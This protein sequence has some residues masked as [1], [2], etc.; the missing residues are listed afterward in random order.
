MLVLRDFHPAPSSA[1]CAPAAIKALSTGQ[2]HAPGLCLRLAVREVEAWALAD[3]EGAAR[4]FA[5]PKNR[6]PREPDGLTDPKAALVALCHRSARREI[7]DG[8]VPRVGSGRAVGPAYVALLTAFAREWDAERASEHSPSLARG[9]SGMRS[10]VVDG[11]W[12]S[13]R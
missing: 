11:R 3:L 2:V 6:I 12:S 1:T 10:C 4:F 7:R 13:G 8:M 5:I 9:M